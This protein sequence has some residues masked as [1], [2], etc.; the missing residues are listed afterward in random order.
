MGREG[1]CL[2]LAACEDMMV[3]SSKL[4]GS[5][6]MLVLKLVE[7]VAAQGVPDLPKES[8]AGVP[9]YVSAVRTGHGIWRGKG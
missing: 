3:I 8:R 9:G 2:L 1:A 4:G 6:D 7:L 5:H